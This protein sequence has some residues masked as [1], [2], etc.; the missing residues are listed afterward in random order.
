MVDLKPRLLTTTGEK[1]YKFMVSKLLTSYKICRRLEY[2][3]DKKIQS[4]YGLNCKRY[5]IND[6][7]KSLKLLDVDIRSDDPNP[8]DPA[9]TYSGHCPLMYKMLNI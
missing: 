6:V 9:Y 2:L 5:L 3:P 4:P 1:L 7:S 8:K